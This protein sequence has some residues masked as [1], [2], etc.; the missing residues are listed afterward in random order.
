MSEIT[1]LVSSVSP[2]SKEFSFDS[3]VNFDDHI[4]K[5]IPNYDIMTESIARLSEYFKDESKIIYDIGCSQGHMLKY[6]KRSNNYKGK[7]IG[8]DMS[9]NLL[10]ANTREY[11][12]V[13][14]VEHDLRTPY[15]FNNACIVYA[16]YTLQFLPR[17]CRKDVLM[18]IWEGLCEGGALFLC[19]KVYLPD[20]QFQDMWSSAYYDYKKESFTEKEIF[21]KERSLRTLLKPN[22]HAEN[23]S[24]LRDCSF[25]KIEQFYQ[26]F[27]FRGVLAIKG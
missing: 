27:Q 5:S 2:K 22:T 6:F 16:M 25:R 17:E 10:P 11:D 12:N 9:R 14:F 18:S 4:A 3:V 7:M 8:L 24:M 23:L 15:K 21:D 19:E 20:G 26:Y 1:G 13:D